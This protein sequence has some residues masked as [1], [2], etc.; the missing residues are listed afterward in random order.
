MSSKSPQ[1]PIEQGED[2]RR[3]RSRRKREPPPGSVHRPI[4]QIPAARSANRS[5]TAKHRIGVRIR[6]FMRH[7]PDALCDGEGDSTCRPVQNT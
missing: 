3:P 7:R 2:A 5:R 4:I 1:Y 6:N